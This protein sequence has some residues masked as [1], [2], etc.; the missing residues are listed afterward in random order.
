MAGL[1]KNA[2]MPSNV[3]RTTIAA[4]GLLLLTA[5]GGQS[6]SQVSPGFQVSAP[7]PSASGGQPGQYL[8]TD[9]AS[10]TVT[11]RL[12]AAQS[13]ALGGF[14]FDGFG[15]GQLKVSVP[16]G[17]KVTVECSNMG[18]VPHSCAIVHG[19]S[20]TTP[21]FP[22]A[23]SPNPT[24]GLTKGEKATF[25]FTP[26]RPGGYRI[27]CLVPGHEES[28]MWDTFTVSESGQPTISS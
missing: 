13:N 26:D 6:N 18:A 1:C 27:A 14:N 9:A 16:A 7:V 5:C 20:D 22:G 21:A 23:A 24:V 4:V 15:N 3:A 25:S 19:A 12:V 28:G 8:T 11:L 17:W 10:K 2:S